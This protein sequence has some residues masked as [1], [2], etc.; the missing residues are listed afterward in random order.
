MSAPHI[1][2]RVPVGVQSAS[3]LTQLPAN[4]TENTADGDPSIRAP[5]TGVRQ[6]EGVPGSWPGFELA[7]GRFG[8]GLN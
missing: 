1:R 7:D 3:H 2:F 5:A 8:P 4:G 6:L